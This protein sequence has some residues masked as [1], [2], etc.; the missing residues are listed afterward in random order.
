MSL[1][2]R[3][4]GTRFLF[5]SSIIS[6]I[7]VSCTFMCDRSA[8]LRL[9]SRGLRAKCGLHPRLNLLIE[10]RSYRATY[11]LRMLNYCCRH[12]VFH[13]RDLHLFLS[14]SAKTGKDSAIRV[15][16]LLLST[17][18]VAFHA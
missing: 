4:N 17:T 14:S 13:Q 6:V 8:R 11:L 18:I 9:G 16:R 3:K 10:F 5:D 1:S 12:D 15:I 7:V 2:E